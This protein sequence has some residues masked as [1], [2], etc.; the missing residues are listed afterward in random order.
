MYFHWNW[1]TKRREVC[2]SIENYKE[3]R[4][5]ILMKKLVTFLKY[6]PWRRI[7]P[8]RAG[9]FL[10]LR[11]QRLHSTG[12]GSV[13]GVDLSLEVPTDEVVVVAADPPTLELCEWELLLEP[14]FTPFPL[15]IKLEDLLTPFTKLFCKKNNIGNTKSILNQ[16]FYQEQKV[17]IFM[18]SHC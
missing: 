13:L 8:L 6:P 3:I 15:W 16:I 18:R 7:C 9:I 4:R 12:L 10:N 11:W 5:V 1:N 17:P 2:T 14:L